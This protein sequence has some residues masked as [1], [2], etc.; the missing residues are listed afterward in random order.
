MGFV[1][2]P[3]PPDMNTRTGLAPSSLPVHLMIGYGKEVSTN[4][5]YAV[6]LDLSLSITFHMPLYGVSQRLD[7]GTG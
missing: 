2:P 4:I 6:G 1:Y 7:Q 3:R 5:V